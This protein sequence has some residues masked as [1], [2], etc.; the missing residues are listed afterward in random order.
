MKKLKCVTILAILCSSLGAE[1]KK[2]DKLLDYKEV[3]VRDVGKDGIRIMHSAGFATIPIESL[4]AEVKKDLG[5]AIEK[6]K[7]PAEAIQGEK[8]GL[9]IKDLNVIAGVDA[10]TKPAEE[11]NK[12]IAASPDSRIYLVK[13]VVFTNENVTDYYKWFYDSEKRVL[14]S[15]RR[16]TIKTVGE[17][18]SWVMWKNLKPDDFAERLPYYDDDIK[19]ISSKYGKAVETFPLTYRDFPEVTKWP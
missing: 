6:E 8:G 16:T 14:I 11:L 2:Y 5:I 13:G 17:H 18:Y 12:M 19:P 9:V 7:V 3:I 4:P 1:E 10:E 15:M